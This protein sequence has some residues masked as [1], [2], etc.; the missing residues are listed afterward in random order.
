[1]NAKKARLNRRI[2][3]A[4]ELGQVLDANGIE[5]NNVIIAHQGNPLR[6]IFKDKTEE[7]KFDKLVEGIE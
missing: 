7:A 6:V 5:Y 3:R 1:M 2:Q 4:A